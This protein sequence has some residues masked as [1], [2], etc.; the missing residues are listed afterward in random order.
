M[1]VILLKDVK[2]V[3]KKFEEKNCADGYALN[4]LLPKKLAVTA[5]SAGAAQVA[6]LKRQ[7]EATRMKE[8]ERVHGIIGSLS[9]QTITLKMKANDQGHLFQKLTKE[10]IAEAVGLEPEAIVLDAPIRET[11]TFSVPVWVGEGKETSFTL[12]VEAA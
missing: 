6:E 9:G 3:G 12:V 8:S 11:G 5:G 2:G 4:F 1:K 7:A 10:K